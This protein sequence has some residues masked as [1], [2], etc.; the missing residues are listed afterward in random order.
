MALVDQKEVI[1]PTYLLA[2]SSRPSPSAPLPDINQ[3]LSVS[4]S[5]CILYFYASRPNRD[6][7]FHHT[8]THVAG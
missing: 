2:L 5:I 3:Y 6:S 8:P 4:V 7:H 1:S